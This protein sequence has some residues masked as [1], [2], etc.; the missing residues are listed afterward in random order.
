[1]NAHGGDDSILHGKEYDLRKEYEVISHITNEV[2]VIWL[3]PVH[4]NVA[5]FKIGRII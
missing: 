1:M 3:L 4:K 2:G 5:G